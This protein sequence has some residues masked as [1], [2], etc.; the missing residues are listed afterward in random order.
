MCSEIIVIGALEVYDV[1]E[2]FSERRKIFLLS[3]TNDLITFKINQIY[4]LG[5]NFLVKEK[6]HDVLASR[7]RS[8]QNQRC[9]HMALVL[10]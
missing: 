2:K 7:E 3:Q 1:L 6:S 4:K 5:V 10:T 8:C 9:L